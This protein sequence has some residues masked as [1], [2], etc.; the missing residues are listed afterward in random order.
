MRFLSLTVSAT[1]LLSLVLAAPR[2]AAHAAASPELLAAASARTTTGFITGKVV[3]Q[4][5][6]P[7]KDV[8]VVADN[9]LFYNS[10]LIGYTAADGTYRIEIGSLPA[11][12]NVTAHLKMNY[13]GSSVSVTLTPENSQV[14]AGGLHGGGVRNFIYRP[15]SSNASN[16]YG[17]VGIIN[18]QRGIG[19]YGVDESKVTL[20]ITPVGKLADGSTGKQMVVKPVLSGDGW[21]VPDVMFGTYTVSATMNGT[22]L[23]VRQKVPRGA[24]PAWAASY[25]GGFTHD[26]FAVRPVMFVELGDDE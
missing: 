22:P 6:K 16:P 4:D 14:V 15:Q 9:T 7:L 20:T 13:Q 25:T 24:F 3:T 23:K 11:T 26:F 19:Q 1:C 10:N 12:W 2:G 21:I 5:G 17:V 18:V 8:E